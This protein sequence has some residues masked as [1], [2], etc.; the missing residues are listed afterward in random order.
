MHSERLRH[1]RD[2]G[3]ETKCLRRTYTTGFPSVSALLQVPTVKRTTKTRSNKHSS[4]TSG[5]CFYR[6]SVSKATPTALKNTGGMTV[7]SFYTLHTDRWMVFMRFML[8]WN[9]PTYLPREL[10]DAAVQSVFVLLSQ[11]TEAVYWFLLRYQAPFVSTSRIPLAPTSCGEG[12]CRRWLSCECI[13]KTITMMTKMMIMMRFSMV[14]GG[15][16]L[17]SSERTH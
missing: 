11:E 13:S 9:S 7:G 2:K 8:E 12:R 15:I 16:E 1:R 17:D 14:R 10:R 4:A 6:E 5:R 3:N